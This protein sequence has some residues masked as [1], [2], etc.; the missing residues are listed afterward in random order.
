L[1]VRFLLP[2]ILVKFTAPAT[3]KVKKTICFPMFSRHSLAWSPG[4]P[5]WAINFP[6]LGPTILPPSQRCPEPMMAHP[7]FYI[8]ILF[9]P[10]PK[11]KFG[12]KRIVVGN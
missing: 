12:K 11:E 5:K 3:A 2:L 8:Y 9:Y 7:D 4:R 1:F 10:V 6:E